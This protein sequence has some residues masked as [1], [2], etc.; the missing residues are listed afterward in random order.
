MSKR[1]GR[2]YLFIRW[3]SGGLSTT[4]L[5]D[6]GWAFENIDA[7]GKFFCFHYGATDVGSPLQQTLPGQRSFWTEKCFDLPE[8][9]KAMSMKSLDRPGY[10]E[11]KVFPVTEANPDAALQLAQRLAEARVSSPDPLEETRQVLTAYGVKGLIPS[12]AFSAP[13]LWYNILPGRSVP[14]R[15]LAIHLFELRADA[16]TEPPVSLDELELA[17]RKASETA[18]LVRSVGECFVTRVASGFL[19]AIN[20][21]VDPQM[22]VVEA[23]RTADRVAETVRALNPKIRHLFVQVLPDEKLF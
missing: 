4:R 12:R 7:Q 22:P 6:V 3:S 21:A 23:R 8:L 9:T 10:D 1:R 18:A 14:I 2:A 20:I 5:G 13:F 15:R 16:N 11:V 17:V 19:V